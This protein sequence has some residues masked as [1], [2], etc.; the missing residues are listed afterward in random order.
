ME[1]NY[2][3][4]GHG[5]SA[6][7][8]VLWLAIVVFFIVVQ[9]RIFQKA[10]KP[11]WAAIIP[12]YN[13]IVYLQIVQR[14]VWWIILFFIPLVNIVIDIVLILDLAKSFGKSVGFAIGMMLLPIIF[15]PILAF[16][17][18]KYVGKEY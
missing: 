11:G 16:G 5:F 15:F 18:A 13:V 4:M 9:W 2:G 6:G 3:H 8:A 10:G 12:I 1:Q 7:F 14:P 17:D